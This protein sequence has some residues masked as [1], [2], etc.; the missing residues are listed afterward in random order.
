MSFVWIGVLQFVVILLGSSH[1]FACGWAFLAIWQG[2]DLVPPS[3]DNG[4][5]L[6]LDLDPA[7]LPD[8][9]GGLDE[10]DESSNFNWLT[11]LEDSKGGL[12]DYDSIASQ[13][14]AAL[15]FTIMTLTTVGCKQLQSRCDTSL[16]SHITPFLAV[17]RWRHRSSN[18]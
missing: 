17:G 11:A 18:R 8:T 14:L 13:Y 15:H 6:T 1:L 4:F 12:R 2:V 7:R 3:K 5:A 10:D 16:V 9:S